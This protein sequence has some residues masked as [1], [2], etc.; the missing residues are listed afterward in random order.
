MKNLLSKF[1]VICLGIFMLSSVQSLA[2][3]DLMI[4]PKRIEFNGG[5]KSQ[6]LNLANSGKDTARYVISV[7]QIRM[8]EDGAFETITE[9]DPGQNFADKYFRIFPRNVVLAPNEAQTVKIQVINMG[10]M[11]PGE[12]RSHLYLRS[13]K[14]KKPLGEIEATNDSS[15]SVKIEAVFGI[16]IPVIIRQGENNAVANLSEASFKMENDS[17]P[18]VHFAFNRSGD[19]SVYGDVSVDHISATGKVTRVGTITGLAVYTP[20][21]K[22]YVNI[23]LKKNA[24]I[25]YSTGKLKVVYSYKGSTDDG[26]TEESIALN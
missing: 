24:G 15:I 14:E 8:K 21:T 5:K 2:Q 22:R 13:E 6:E 18:T 4:F 1:P 19:M 3:G 26:Y 11:Q 17:I 20:T 12:Y 16:S 25:D 10:E 23:P 7:I 9:P